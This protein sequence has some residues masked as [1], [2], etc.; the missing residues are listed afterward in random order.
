MTVRHFAGG[1]DYEAVTDFLGGLYQPDNRD[2]NWFW[3]VWEYAYTHPQ[4]DAASTGKTGLWEDGGRIVG[5]ATYE[6]RLGEAFFNTH[7]DYASL[8]PEM[9]EYAEEHLSARGAD[10][11]RRLKAYVNDFDSAFEEEVVGR[12]YARDPNGDRP[13]AQF[14]IP[15]S[16][17]EIGVPDGFHLQTLADDNDLGR[18]DRCLHR[19]FDHP[20]DPPSDGIEGR[21]KMQSGPHY[22]KDLAIV[23]VAPS[24]EFVSFAG[25]WFDAANRLGYVEPV[26]TD[27]DYRR[28]GL[29]RACVLE[30]IRRCGELGATVAY[31][32]SDQPFYLSLGF[33]RL[34]TENCWAKELG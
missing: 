16:F 25:L 27:P 2:G 29:A 19:G 33:E 13:L 9:L 28:R 23:A 26:A 24:G 1:S 31:V 8:K 7:P 18:W 3:P 10:G 17:P 14:V 22:R 34:H 11:C 32:G 12:G 4:F 30:G 6:L 15:T 20:G 5:L 21:Q